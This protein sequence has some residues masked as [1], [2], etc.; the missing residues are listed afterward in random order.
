MNIVA[1]QAEL[2][3]NAEL[4]VNLLNEKENAHLDYSS[5]SISWLDTYID[6]HR[7]EL[8]DDDKQVLQEKFGSY[9]GEVIRLNYGGQWHQVEAGDWAI[10]FNDNLA[11]NPFDIVDK[12]L[13]QAKPMARYY[14]RIPDLFDLNANNN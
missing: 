6:Q 11:T 10:V 1:E 3:E 2:R 7:A 9:L 8:S 13:N 5:D 14:A 12:H 4:V